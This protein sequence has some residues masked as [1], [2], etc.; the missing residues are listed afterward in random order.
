MT[1]AELLVVNTDFVEICGQ[2]F[3]IF[4]SLFLNFASQIVHHAGGIDS[5]LK[6]VVRVLPLLFGSVLN[7]CIHIL[8]REMGILSLENPREVITEVLQNGVA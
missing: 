8:E 4:Y 2:V 6:K 1:L 5:V 3:G 7:L